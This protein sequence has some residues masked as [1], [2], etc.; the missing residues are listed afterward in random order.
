ML[1]IVH[2]LLFTDHIGD[3]GRLPEEIKVL[4]DSGLYTRC[5]CSAS[6]KGIIV[7]VIACLIKL[8]SQPIVGIFEVKSKGAAMSAS[9]TRVRQCPSIRIIVIFGSETL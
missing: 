6:A 8:V 9:A 7:Q 2:H 4:A 5:F 3:F 1:E